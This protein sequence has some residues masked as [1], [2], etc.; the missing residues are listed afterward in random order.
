MNVE[1]LDFSYIKEQFDK[2]QKL[3]GYISV[4]DLSR[5]VDYK[6]P[7]LPEYITGL[8]EFFVEVG[9]AK[10]FYSTN[11]TPHGDR[12]MVIH[13]ENNKIIPMPQVF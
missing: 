9:A 1:D 3:N 4:D 11:I 2:C 10:G 13:T 6:G 8:A 5:I 12:M 7:E